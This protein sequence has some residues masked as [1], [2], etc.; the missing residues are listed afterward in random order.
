[1][2]LQAKQ[3]VEA[4]LQQAA[5]A[6]QRAGEREIEVDQAQAQLTQ[7]LA[8]AAA[9]EADLQRRQVSPPPAC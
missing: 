4:A 6:A 5:E 3:A 7:R 9:Q 8:A 2:D 1:M